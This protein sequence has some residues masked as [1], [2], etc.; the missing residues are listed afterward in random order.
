MAQ[1]SMNINISVDI[2]IFIKMLFQHRVLFRFFIFSY[3]LFNMSSTN[4]EFKLLSVFNRDLSKGYELRNID[5]I[6]VNYTPVKNLTDLSYYYFFSQFINSFSINEMK[7]S[8]T[9]FYNN[10]KNNINLY[11]VKFIK[12]FPKFDLNYKVNTFNAEKNI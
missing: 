8:E 4:N 7:L 6:N 5:L 12:I 11:F 10:K 9:H 3:K 1:E 2:H